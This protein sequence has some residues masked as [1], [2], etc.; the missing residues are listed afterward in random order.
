MHMYILDKCY[1]LSSLCSRF[2]A[3]S[4]CRDPVE[5]GISVA[6]QPQRA[7]PAVWFFWDDCGIHQN[8]SA[9]NG[10]DSD[11]ESDKS[12]WNYLPFLHKFSHF[13]LYY[14]G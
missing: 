7:D 5:G 6:R 8:N 12:G 9:R 2:T 14:K 4:G 11:G 1:Q 13:Q 10:S 3:D